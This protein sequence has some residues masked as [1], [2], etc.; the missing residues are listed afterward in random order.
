LH[1]DPERVQDPFSGLPEVVTLRALGNKKPR[2]EKARLQWT[3]ADTLALEV[4]L[5]GNETVL[6]TVTLPGHDPVALPPVCLPYA[7]EFEPPA[8]AAQKAG[9]DGPSN[10]WGML[11]LERLARITGGK[12]R[13]E[14]PSIWRDM[15]RLPRLIPLTL[16]LVVAAS[17]VFLL[18]V[19]ERLTGV[20]ARLGTVAG[21]RR[22]VRETPVSRA[23]ATAALPAASSMRVSAPANAA[24]TTPPAIPAAPTCGSTSAPPT[25]AARPSPPKTQPP[26]ILEAL[27][28]AQKRG[29]TRKP[30]T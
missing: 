8:L 6:A 1:L 17:I 9:A 23:E 10:A 30:P 4:L 26:G 18:E 3:G 19:L 12:E 11:A 7:P 13:I 15:I 28:E 27:R 2:T 22:R 21:M 14:L 24:T 25:P 20:L 5:T 16:W 29:R